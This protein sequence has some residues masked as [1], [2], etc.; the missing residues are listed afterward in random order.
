MGGGVDSVVVEALEE[1]VSGSLTLFKP[2]NLCMKGDR[3]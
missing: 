1:V 3:A 2:A